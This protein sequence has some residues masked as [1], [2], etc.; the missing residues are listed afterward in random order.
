[1][2]LSNSK[3]NI[4]GLSI[5]ARC[6]LV[7]GIAALWL[8]ISPLNGLAQGLIPIDRGSKV[9]LTMTQGTGDDI[10]KLKGNFGSMYGLIQFDPTHLEQSSLDISFNTNT[11]RTH[12]KG[13]EFRLKSREFLDA[14]KYPTLTIRS[15]SITQDRPGGIVYILKGTLTIKGV[16]RP[17]RIQFTATKSGS[18]YLFMGLMQFKRLDFG[19]GEKGEFDDNVSVFLQVNSEKK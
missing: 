5:S 1:M 2:Q 8:F 16:T 10:K 9:E 15:T 12:D 13:D 7:V 17:T 14:A 11:L 6:T 3:F 18:G 4:S 19:M